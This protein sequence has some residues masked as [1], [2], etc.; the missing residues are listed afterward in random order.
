MTSLARLRYVI[1]TDISKLPVRQ[2]GYRF[3]QHLYCTTA[4]I[5]KRILNPGDKGSL[6]HKSNPCV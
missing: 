4:T 6:L 2:Q 3:R 1:K 5:V